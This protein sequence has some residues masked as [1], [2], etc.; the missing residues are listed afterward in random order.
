A[1]YLQNQVALLNQKLQISL[2]GRIQGFHLER[3]RFVTTGTA[4][5]Y[6]TIPLQSPPRALTG[7]VALSYFMDRTGTKFRAHAGN[8]YR[9]PALSERFGSGFSFNST[10]AQVVFSPFGDPRLSPDRY[11]SF[12]TGVDQY[13]AGSRGRLSATFFYART[14]QTIL[15]DS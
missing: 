15:F 4:N 1:A 2:S 6:A 13:F 14:V 3:P 5:N 8:S 7:D 9:A 12:D 10:T 11:N